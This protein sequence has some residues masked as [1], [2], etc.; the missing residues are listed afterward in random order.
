[1]ENYAGSYGNISADPLFCDPAI[2]DYH[3]QPESECQPANNSCGVTFGALTGTCD[4]FSPPAAV[5][6]LT[7]TGGFRKV[8]LKWTAAAESDLDGFEI[9][10]ARW[11]DESGA[12]VYPEYDDHEGAIIP[13]RPQTRDAAVQSDEWNL[14]GTIDSGGE[15]FIDSVSQRGVYYYELFAF[16]VDGNF[17]EPATDVVRATSYWLGDVAG[18]EGYDGKVDVADL[19]RLA[20]GYGAIPTDVETYD[21]ELDVGPTDDFSV[22]G[23]P[24]TDDYVGFD[25][26]MII[27]LN[28]G[29]AGPYRDP[30]AASESALRLVWVRTAERSWTLRLAEPFP[31]LKGIRLTAVLPETPDVQVS[32]GDLIEQQD[33]PVFLQNADRQGLN[34]GLAVMGQSVGWQGEGNLFTIILPPELAPALL[35]VGELTLVVRDVTNNP[36][37]FVLSQQ[38]EASAVPLP[39]YYRLG[40]N[41][42]NPFNPMTKIA[43][44]LP[45]DQRVRMAIYDLR[46]RCVTTLVDERLPAGRHE[47]VWQGTDS[48]GEKVSSGVYFYRLI[49]GPF[50]QTKSMTLI[51]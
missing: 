12:S 18:P 35:D 34:I 47:A 42:P 8:T 3:L 20:S 5:T 14:A 32:G 50:T 29:E 17:S 46:G 13:T 38:E 21:P 37:D 7:A 44:D 22:H 19:T 16:D 4:D 43:F 40:E 6:E 1:M 39:T 33:D 36:L 51:K 30:P 24:V 15:E 28:Y 10:R 26:L 9:Y 48:R 31:A 45:K 27:G 11:H 2:G 49:A 23:I 25:D 41:Y